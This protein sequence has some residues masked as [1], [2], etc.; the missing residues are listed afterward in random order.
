MPP[1]AVYDISV[2]TGDKKKSGTDAN[3]KICLYCDDG[4]K[5][6][7]YNLDK[8]FKN[9]FERGQKDS[10][11][12]KGMS[13]T[14]VD[15]IELWRDTAG[16]M[17]DWFVD[18]VEVVCSKQVFVFPFF[19]WIKPN[20]RYKIRHLDTSLPDND[21]FK[22]QRRME[23]NNA[24]EQYE[25]EVKVPGFPA[26]VKSLPEDENFSFDYVWDITKRKAHAILMSKI[27][28]LT[29][30]S[31]KN[32][33]DLKNMY[34]KEVLV[35]PESVE[36]WTDDTYF[37][38]Q[39]I[40]KMNNT[41]IELCTAV[42][43]K[44]VV[45]DDMVKESLEGF[46]LDTAIQ[47]KRLFV[48]DYEIMDSL[49]CGKDDTVIC[50][51]IALFFVNGKQK[52]MPIAI[53]LFQ[54]PGKDNPVFL[55][56]DP[57]YTWITAKLWFNHADS[58]YH[59]SFTHLGGTHLM[60]EGVAVITH[61]NMSP[62]HP[63]FKLL[64]PHFLYLLAINTRALGNLVAPGGW[65]DRALSVGIKGMFDVIRRKCLQWR[66]D[67]DGT[68]PKDLERRGLLGD[69]V[70]PGYYFRDD[71][72]QVY[73]AIFNFVVKYL[74][75]YYESTAKLLGDTELQDWAAEMVL[76]KDKGGLGLLGVPG[77]GTVTTID[78]LAT[79]ITSNIYMCSVAHAAANFP[80]YDQYAF[81]PAYPASMR[82]KPPTDKKPLSEMSVLAA[83]PD[84]DTTLDMMVVTH[85]LSERTTNC[86][87]NFE[88]QYVYD[89]PALAVID[90]FKN[91][92][93][94]ISQQIKAKNKTRDPPYP[95]LDPEEIPNAISI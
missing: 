43:K 34:T 22:E 3:V 4:N 48:V 53:Q 63:V 52:L 89:P 19:R 81:P 62:S 55:P 61:R 51:P 67:I 18:I 66:L 40:S 45:T 28:K 1:T 32:L 75:L 80:Q 57:E 37:G 94:M 90:E 6:D 42:P 14:R 59:Q 13:L 74:K 11:S 54:N 7:N 20:Y 27:V 25:L 33:D 8:F 86:L 47:A 88:V 12:V 10:F 87:G 41:V 79:I 65:A 16:I 15:Y 24:R 49:P 77:S 71:A 68:L 36:H 70:L 31:W 95:W 23:I 30:G 5:T 9:D 2:K 56:A 26:Q 17:D 76:S 83:L 85:I 21:P 44:M 73:N 78:Q 84:K 29:S 69:N 91:A 64:A 82:G 50:A 92:L 35:L 58:T 46:T 39:R 60:M 38:Y 72:L 93:K